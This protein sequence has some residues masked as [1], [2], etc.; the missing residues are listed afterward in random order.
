MNSRDLQP[1]ACG[2]YVT[3]CQSAYLTP[4]AGDEGMVAGA[5]GIDLVV[6]VDEVV[7]IHPSEVGEVI[8]GIRMLVTGELGKVLHHEPVSS[9]ADIGVRADHKA[10]VVDAGQGGVFGDRVLNGIR[11]R[12]VGVAEEAFGARGAIIVADDLAKV[13]KTKGGDG[14]AVRTVKD[15]D[16]AADADESGIKTG[17]SVFAVAAEVAI[18]VHASKEGVTKAR[19]IELGVGGAVKEEAVVDVDIFRLVGRAPALLILRGRADIDQEGPAD[20]AGGV[21][22]HGV[23]GLGAREEDGPAKTAVLAARKAA[24]GGIVVVLANGGTVVGD[25]VAFGIRGSTGRIIV[26][27]HHQ[28]NCTSRIGS[29]R[30]GAGSR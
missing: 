7:V 25:A 24:V 20:E 10:G 19:E 13:V 28:C 22:A 1:S 3:A 11:K 12:A 2:L 15:G 26:G 9:K 21:G 17:H 18:V 6:A 5:E 27:R 4:E 30:G 16:D 8:G 23:G 29:W 14:E